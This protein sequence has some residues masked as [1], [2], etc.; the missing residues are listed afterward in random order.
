[1][2][3]TNHYSRPLGLFILLYLFPLWAFAQSISVQG[4]VKDPS[5]EPIIGASILEVGT[6]NGT[7]TDVYGSFK[8]T[9][10]SKGTLKVSFIGYQTQLIAVAGK[11]Q[12]AVTMK[13]DTEVLDEVVVVGY[14]QMRRSDLTGAVVSVSSDAISKSVTTSIDQVLQGRAAGVQVQQNTGMPGGSSSIRIRGVNSLN[15]S[16]EPIFVID[17]V[18]ID[19]STGSGNDNALASIN[20]SDIVSMDVLKDAS[21]TAI[22]GARAANGVIIITTKRGSKG[23]ASITYDGYVGWQQMP[24][25]LDMMDLR[26]YA[27]HKNERADMGIVE[28]DNN[29]IRPDLLGKGTDWQNEMFAT[30]MMHS[31]NLSVAGGADKNTYALGAGYLNQ[32]GIAI[33]SG[34]KRL[35]LRGSFDSQV[36]KYLKMGV[37]FAFSNSNQKLTVSEESLI[38]IALKQ[39][40]NVPVRNAEGNYDGP[41][42]NEYVQNNP[43]GLAMIKK[44]ENEKMGI[45]ANTYAEAT[46]IDGLT[47][48][49]ELSFDYG[50]TNTYR[51]DPS[52]KFGALVNEVREGNVAKSYNK[53]WSW[54]NIVNYNQTFAVHNINVMLGQEMQKSNWEYLSGYRSGYLTNSATDLDA[55]DATTAK[56]GNNSGASSILSYFGRAFY[57]YDDKYLATFTIRRDGSSKFYKDNRWGWFPS[58]ALAWKV[59]NENFLKE[60][61]V[62]NNLK[63]RLGWGTVGNQNV[64]NY[65]YTSTYSSVA[66]N[67]GTGLIA[68]NTPN[69]DLKWETTYSSNIGI[70]VNLFQNRIEFIADIYYK[71]TKNL[72]LQLPL[73][74]FAGTT[75][76]GSTS[77][78]WANIG[79]LEN[80]GLELTL[81]TV[82][83]DKGG[84][85]WRSNFVFSMNRNKV[86]SLDT[87]SSIIN[88]TIQSG[89]DIT[90]VTHTA[91]GQAIGQFYGYKVIGRFEKATDFYYKDESGKITPTALPT[92]MTIGENG[93][94]IGDYIFEDRNKDGVINEE[95]RTYIGNPEPEFTYGIGNSFSYKGFD[96]SIYLTGSY[97][98]EVVNYMRRSLENP[99]E[100]TNLLK[101]AT[102]YAHLE[103]INPN[104][105]NDYRNI[106]IASGDADMCR[107][108]ASPAS[109]TSN[110]RFSDKFVED[111]S[112]LRVQNVSLGYTLPRQWVNKIGLQ[113]LKLYCNLQNVFTFTKYSGYDPEIGSTN[114]DALMT[115]IDNYRYPSPRIYTF[116]LNLSF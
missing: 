100:N 67:W 85:Q 48:K 95:D 77:A 82:N 60:N 81:N 36:K 49:T 14:G 66:T 46:I 30:A 55:G 96:L 2:K 106:R 75:G 10:S 42:T 32:D 19:G 28:A 27:I 45:R 102:H 44:N 61:E 103:R 13:E 98:N 79:S 72:L 76:S 50:V 4:V 47:Y 53:Y 33:G 62:I 21:A 63:L 41:D 80:K 22:Y 105:P 16:N 38:Q 91:V 6:T 40:P 92:G 7:I 99:R 5:G 58:A 31:H 101:K 1:M 115:G 64:A 84:F 70:D 52:Y 86:L 9:T 8:L 3:N 39:T 71:K 83:I 23:E 97:G 59:S 37:N 20:P 107:I 114:Q 113:N 109:S 108:G 68:S 78:P 116:G 26:D 24:D 54:R 89:S 104:G 34:F 93:V 17:G 73:P 25:K 90:P 57:A 87:E 65:A 112:Y 51:F 29:F 35:N 110:F 94:W 12:L 18:V 111:G 74:A 15:A 56:N 69:K 11:K 43:V 88:K